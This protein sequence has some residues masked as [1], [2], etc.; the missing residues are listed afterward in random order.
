MLI[1]IVYTNSLEF[2]AFD[3]GNAWKYITMPPIVITAVL[4]QTH[5]YFHSM[6]VCDCLQYP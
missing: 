4:F 3:V 6:R 2:G 1:S 5:D